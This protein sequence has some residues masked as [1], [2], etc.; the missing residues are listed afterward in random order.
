MKSEQQYIELY[1]E[2]S[3]LIKRKSCEVMNAVRYEAFQQFVSSGFPTRKV[4]RY[5]YT[6]VATAFAP[7][8]GISLSPLEVKPSL[9]IYNIKDAPIDVRPY[10]HKIA[11][12]HDP[13]TALNT[14]L[15]HEALL[16]HVPKNTLVEDPIVVDN[17]LRGT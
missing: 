14:A 7:N 2:A 9:Y 16:V 17:W 11:D 4:E 12:A 8:Y 3:D 1:Q 5:R 15:V 13:I 10:Y 6:D